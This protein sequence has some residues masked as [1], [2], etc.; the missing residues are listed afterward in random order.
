MKFVII[1]GSIAL[2]ISVLLMIVAL[3]LKYGIDTVCYRMLLKTKVL[4]FP[5]FMAED[6]LK[7]MISKPMSLSDLRCLVKYRLPSLP[8]R[9]LWDYIRPFQTIGAMLVIGGNMHWF[10]SGF[11]LMAVL[12]SAIMLPFAMFVLTMYLILGI[13]RICWSRI[14]KD[15]AEVPE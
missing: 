12:L 13:E 10:E 6:R 2:G 4:R 9:C 5:V 11:V 14:N 1:L 8:E 3:I 15:Y 7:K